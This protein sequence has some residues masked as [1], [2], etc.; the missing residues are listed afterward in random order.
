MDMPYFYV[1]NNS[2]VAYSKLKMENLT[3]IVNPSKIL[4]K[5]IQDA[6]VI[7]TV[8]NISHDEDEERERQQ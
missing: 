6:N 8:V 3:A 5:I 2:F 1:K 7:K 4:A